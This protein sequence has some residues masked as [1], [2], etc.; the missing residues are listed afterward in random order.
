MR[1]HDPS[2]GAYGAGSY[3]CHEALHMASVLR[4]LVEKQLCEHPAV[5][6]N[7]EWATLAETARTALFD[8]YQAIGTVHLAVESLQ[9]A[10]ALEVEVAMANVLRADRDEWKRRAELGDR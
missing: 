5:E 9:A 3:G 2:K 4:D 8:L 7:R 6:A 10:I 1:L